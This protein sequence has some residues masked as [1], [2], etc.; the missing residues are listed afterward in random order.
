MKRMPNGKPV[1]VEWL[2]KTGQVMTGR[3]YRD[4][5]A[6]PPIPRLGSRREQKLSASQHRGS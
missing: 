3:E 1:T 6:T 4:R 5:C 2:I